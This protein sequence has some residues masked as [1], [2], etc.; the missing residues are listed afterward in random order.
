MHIRQPPQVCRVAN[1]LEFFETVWNLLALSGTWRLAFLD[2]TSF[3][4][5]EIC[6][7]FCC[8]IN[9][10]CLLLR[11]YLLP[12][13]VL[14][15]AWEPQQPNTP[16]LWPDKPALRVQLTQH[17]CLYSADGGS[18]QL[19]TALQTSVTWL[20]LCP[21]CHFSTLS[22]SCHLCCCYSTK[23][24]SHIGYLAARTEHFHICVRNFW[25]EKL[26]TLHVWAKISYTTA[27]GHKQSVIM[28]CTQVTTTEDV[29][30]PSVH[31]S[32]FD[33]GE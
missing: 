6:L 10:I 12:Q 8:I 14:P 32:S 13:A 24:I 7:V 26:A 3:G 30:R 21:S 28:T 2:S 4:K 25:L 29:A 9:I 1:H 33:V 17:N 23:E 20:A 5:M 31:R 16:S 11:V 18:D 27:N 15:Q 19:G 22:T